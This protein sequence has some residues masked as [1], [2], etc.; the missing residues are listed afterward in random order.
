MFLRLN[1]EERDSVQE[2]RPVEFIEELREI[3]KR[4]FALNLKT[5]RREEPR[6]LT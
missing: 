3:K 6:G 1:I 4:K 5:L 2:G